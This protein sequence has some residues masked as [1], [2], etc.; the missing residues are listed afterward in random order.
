[1]LLTYVAGNFKLAGLCKLIMA[2]LYLVLGRGRFGHHG[3]RRA[4]LGELILL[5]HFWHHWAPT[6][7]TVLSHPNSITCQ[8]PETGG[9]GIVWSLHCG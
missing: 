5:T 1:M 6:P 8:T 3:C 7:H 9:R 4:G 2:P